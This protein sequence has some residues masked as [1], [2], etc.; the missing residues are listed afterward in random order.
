[1]NSGSNLLIS[2][3]KKGLATAG[4]F[5]FMNLFSDIEYL[6]YLGW[7]SPLEIIT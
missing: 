6:W 3:K 4:P 1:M 5:S 2:S 7:Q